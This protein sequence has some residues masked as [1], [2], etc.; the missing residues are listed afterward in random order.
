MVC[1]INAVH[2]PFTF[3][4]V[5]SFTLF[6]LDKQNVS[7]QFMECVFVQREEM[8]LETEQQPR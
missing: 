3:N 8:A 5:A 7:A 4:C 1:Y 6:F 2:L